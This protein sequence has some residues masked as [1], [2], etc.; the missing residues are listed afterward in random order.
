[1]EKTNL[2][3]VL[4][5]NIIFFLVIS[6]IHLARILAQWDV[7]INRWQVPYWL[8]AIA[9]LILGLLIFANAKHLK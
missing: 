3:A 4:K 5:L 2:K 6:S 8:N 7:A 1:M 9:M